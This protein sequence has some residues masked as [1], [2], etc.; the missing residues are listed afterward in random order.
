MGHR[1]SGAFPECHTRLLPRRSRYDSS[2]FVHVSDCWTVTDVLP[3]D[4]IVFRLLQNNYSHSCVLSLVSSNGRMTVFLFPFPVPWIEKNLRLILWTDLC[5]WRVYVRICVCVH[6]C[7]CV[8]TGLC[9]RLCD[10]QVAF[11]ARLTTGWKN[12]P[13][14]HTV[15][16]WTGIALCCVCACVRITTPLS[17]NSSVP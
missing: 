4:F 14:S 8:Y 10:V 16:D 12:E 6:A 11:G 17:T 15:G 13:A 5:F 7:V 2:L 9:Q 1:R 3:I